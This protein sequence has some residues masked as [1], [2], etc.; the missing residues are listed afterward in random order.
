MRLFFI[1]FVFISTS[2]NAQKK[3]FVEMLPALQDPKIFLPFSS[4]EIIDAR[5]D[6]TYVGAFAKGFTFRQQTVH[7]YEADFPGSFKNYFPLILERFIQ[8]DKSSTDTLVILV[9]RFRLADHFDRYKIDPELILNVSM[10]FFSRN[11]QEYTKLNAVEKVYAVSMT[12]AH[13]RKTLDS[14]R[15]IAFGKHLEK[16]FQDRSWSK[17][18]TVFTHAEIESGI[19]KRFALPI[20]TDSVI[21]VGCYR[22]F[23]EFI[24]NRPSISNV[25]PVYKEGLK[26]FKTADGRMIPVDSCWGGSDGKNVFV[27]FRKT[28]NMLFLKDHG[29]V[30]RSYRSTADIKPPPDYG[31]A[32]LQYGLIP[33]MFEAGIDWEPEFFHLNMDN[34][35]IFL[36]ELFGEFTKEENHREILRKKN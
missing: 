3:E 30:L 32:A 20:F 7:K 29:F 27:V 10:S 4:V 17:T 24:M 1:L 21:Q 11:H 36:E 35:T 13:K 6:K 22:N 33:A 15:T 31:S 5:F 9:K 14:L 18:S 12:D 26:G 28:F 8:F 23:N 25:K 16:I 19:L 2:A 34:G